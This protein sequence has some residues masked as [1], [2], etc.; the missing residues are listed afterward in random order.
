MPVT[1]ETSADPAVER[2]E[3]IAVPLG[4]MVVGCPEGG[5]Y[6]QDEVVVYD[7]PGAAS[8]RDARPIAVLDVLSHGVRGPENIAKVLKVRYGY[9]LQPHEVGSDVSAVKASLGAT[10]TVQA[11][12]GAIQNGWITINRGPGRQAPPKF[13]Q[14]IHLLASGA[15]PAQIAQT[16]GIRTDSGTK[17][18]FRNLCLFFH[19]DNPYAALRRSYEWGVRT[20]AGSVV[21]HQLVQSETAYAF[22]S[23]P[24]TG[25]IFPRQEYEDLGARGRHAIDGRSKGLSNEEV[26]S[27]L[28][29]P[30]ISGDAVKHA[31]K[32]VFKAL[33]ASSAGEAALKAL[34]LDE[35]AYS[36]YIEPE[37][38][39]ALSDPQVEAAVLAALG[40]SDI[41]IGGRLGKSGPTIKDRMI[42]L[43][44]KVGVSSRTALGRRLLEL[45]ILVPLQPF[46][47]SAAE[48][49]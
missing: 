2:W 15:T 28:F 48:T 19:A 21:M 46:S 13:R 33:D 9:D 23:V 10:T 47:D 36:R 4:R 37:A 49:G 35:L 44:P 32:H 18:F 12:D 16:G 31:L 20:G 17:Q 11:I 30:P 24:Q 6:Q 40:L 43:L 25:L 3:L 5:T 1:P 41:E 27:K 34:L 8:P 39:E 42:A 22:Q 7:M 26:G 45:G 29:T 14:A 38:V